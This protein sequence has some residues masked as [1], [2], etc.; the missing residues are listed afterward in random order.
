MCANKYIHAIR[1]DFKKETINLKRVGMGI[2]EC[3][4]ERK[5]KGE[6]LKLKYNLKKSLGGILKI[7]LFIC[8]RNGPISRNIN[9]LKLR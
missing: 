2:W 8:R 5:G 9:L 1:L 4:A 7:R 3:L 6:L